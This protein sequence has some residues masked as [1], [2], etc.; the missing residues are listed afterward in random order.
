MGL[1]FSHPSNISL[2]RCC[3][4][5]RK[6]NKNYEEENTVFKLYLQRLESEKLYKIQ[7]KQKEEAEKQKVHDADQ[8]HI[9]NETFVFYKDD[10]ESN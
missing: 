3:T 2:I 10:E 5:V 7:Q 9:F 6:P 4:D 8:S 1:Y